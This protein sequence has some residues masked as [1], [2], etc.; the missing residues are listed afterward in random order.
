MKILFIEDDKMVTDALEELCRMQ[1][2]DCDVANEGNL[3][4][5]LALN[6]IYDVIVLDIMLPNKDGLEILNLIR[7]NNISVPVL[8]LTA[9]GTVE[10]KVSSLDLGADDFMV[11]PFSTKELFARI[12]ALA[13]R[14]DHGLSVTNIAYGDIVFD[15]DRNLLSFNDKTE[16]LTQKEAKILE[17]LLRRPNQVFTRAQIIDRVW[18]LDNIINRNNIEIYIHN[19]RKKLEGSNVKIDTLRGIGYIIGKKNVQNDPF[20]DSL[21]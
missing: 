20:E 6:P 17:L 1:N 18:G 21:V 19:L 12:R 8:M 15:L 13:R 7:E 2:I 4:A 10:D 14:L 9:K 11:K 3:G 5:K 16:R